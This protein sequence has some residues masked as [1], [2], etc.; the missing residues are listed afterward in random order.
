MRGDIIYEIYGMHKGREDDTFLVTFKTLK[1]AQAE[2]EKLQ[3]RETDGQNWAARYHNKG[4]AIRE[5]IVDTDFEIPLKPKPRDKYFIKTTPKPNKAGTWNSTIVDVYR[6]DIASKSTERVCQYVRTYAMLQTFEPF[7]QGGREYALISQD[8]TR[9]SVLDLAS[10][11]VIA[12]ELP[13]GPPGS[14]FCPVGFYVPDWWDVNEGSVIPGSHFW[15]KDFEWP[16]GDFGFVWGCYWGDDS[17]WKVQFLDLSQIQRGLIHR[18][19]RFGYIE[20]ATGGYENPS[21]KFNPSEPH[22]SRPPHFIR[23]WKEDGIATVNFA[24]EMDFDLSSGKAK[25]WQRLQN[26]SP[27]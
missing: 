26:T 17:S 25:S 23:L 12:E 1:E 20:L 5:K 19:E 6:R 7:R 14:G 13:S 4:F 21:L 24:V 3:T 22:D 16:N 27:D 2:V 10:G 8:Y 11:K 9:I 18:E 15:N